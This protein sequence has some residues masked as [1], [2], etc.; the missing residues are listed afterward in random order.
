MVPLGASAQLA[1][2]NERLAL[3]GSHLGESFENPVFVTGHVGIGGD[4]EGYG[5]DTGYGG[6]L[7]FRPGHPV[8][9]LGTLFRWSVGTIAQVDYQRLDGGGS[10]TAIDLVA[11][12]YFGNRGTE[13]V[14]VNLFLGLGTGGAFRKLEGA[15][16][17]EDETH[18]TWLV[19]AGQEWFFR[20]THMIFIKGQYRW[21]LV[22]DEVDGQWSVMVGAGFRWPW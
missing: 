1:E 6:S 12:R 21:F 10:W 4:Y 22:D 9:L 16:E 7:I 17:T 14:P 15:E 18:W 20:P 5:T 8:N 2:G 3:P 13:A 19:E 11:R